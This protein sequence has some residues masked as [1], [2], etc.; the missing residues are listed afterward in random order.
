MNSSVIRENI[1]SR[2]RKFLTKDENHGY[3]SQDTSAYT[4]EFVIFLFPG[5]SQ[6]SLSSLIDPLRI[7]NAA[8]SLKLYSWR[9]VS[10]D[11][12]PVTCA[13]GLTIAVTGD[14]RSERTR[15]E[16]SN[17]PTSVVLCA[18]EGVEQL[19]S[20]DLGALLRWCV[21]HKVDI[22]T[23]GTGTWLVA[24]LG[25][26]NNSRCTIHWEKLSAL[27]ETF[28]DLA[29]DDALFVRDGLFVTCAGEFAAFDLAID[30]LKK[31]CSPDL[32]NTVCQHV[33]ADRWRDG[34][35]VQSPPPG[36]RYTGRNEKLSGVV[37]LMQQN[38]E[39]P[40][41]LKEIANE[42][43]LS[44]RQIER[45]FHRYLATTP[46]QFYRSLRLA[47]ARQL[48]ISTS[49]SILKIAV[50]CG[51]ASSSNFSTCFRNRFGI[52]PRELRR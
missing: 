30:I 20:P 45:M 10:M 32:V 8:S 14:L 3:S 23:L 40:L 37:R 51:F 49:L 18:G 5:F 39:D 26:L 48:L 34:S 12:K 35:T 6:L 42:V 15:I 4:S 19:R 43:C 44:R 52:L 9:L 38:V 46:H 11:G 29:V 21:R 50:A 28:Y 27:S 1:A 36:L 2:S 47:R 7:A 17:T 22:Y 25:L 24:E 31:R 41:S 16:T 13:S 33:T